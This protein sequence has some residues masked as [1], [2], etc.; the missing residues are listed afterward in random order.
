MKCP[1]R[2]ITKTEN[3]ITTTKFA[4]CYRMKCPWYT[5]E[6]TIND[7]KIISEDC[8]RC[9]TEHARAN[10]MHNFYKGQIFK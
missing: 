9:H 5:Y 4:E 6:S 1:Y 10:N 7:D 8:Q 3:N 2:P